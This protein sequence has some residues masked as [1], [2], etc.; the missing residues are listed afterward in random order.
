MLAL[1]RSFDEIRVFLFVWIG[2][3]VSLI[4]SRLTAF[5]LNIWIYQQTGSV[6]EFGL[7]ILCG[8]LPGLLLSP[9][10]G[11]F[12]DR[13]S[14]RWTMIIADS[15]VGLC[16]LT[17]A[18][19]F[20]TDHLS[21]WALYGITALSSCF[22]A[23]QST[24]YISATTLLV[25]KDQLIRASG[26]T[27]LARAVAKIIAPVVAG[28]LLE[29]IQLQGIILI[30]FATLVVA[31]IPLLL[32]RFPEV[33]DDGELAQPQ[34][35]FE[36][37]V[38]GWQYLI[39]R[40]GLLGLMI[41][42][43]ASNVVI[44]AFSVLSTPLILSLTSPT[45]LGTVLSISSCGLV[46]G[47]LLMSIWKSEEHQIIKT[48]FRC[49]VAAGLF[50][51]VSG[52]RPSIYLFAIADFFLSIMFPIITGLVQVIFQTKVAPDVQGRVFS[53]QEPL[54]TAGITLGYAIAGPLDEL[55]FEPLMTSDWFLANTIVEMIGFGPGHGIALLN[56]VMGGLLVI[57][58]LCVYQYPRLQRLEDEIP[59]QTTVT[60]EL[61]A[62]S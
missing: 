62:S 16:T 5:G 53:I 56:M 48:L 9:V 29:A 15:Y 54:A 55:V 21:I 26:L 4:G 19:L 35:F 42:L 20:A 60:V 49:M 22:E 17:I 11:V 10:T 52:L 7:L 3:F 57:A 37:V 30:D 6:T 8:S 2:Q 40:P 36:A 12:V 50:I 24:A 43:A 61:S 14:R 41:F 51:L 44:G 1:Y 34:P 31:L 39:A 25:P 18:W 28:L 27:R 33:R 45:G 46:V 38:Y 47:S 23:F 32:L 13:W 58:T 59:D